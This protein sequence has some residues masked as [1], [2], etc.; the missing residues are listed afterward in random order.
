NG[1]YNKYIFRFSTDYEKYDLRIISDLSYLGLN[2]VVLD[3]GVCAHINDNEDL[4]LFSNK[5]GATDVKVVSDSLISSDMQLYKEGIKV[6][7]PKQNTLYS[8][9]TRNK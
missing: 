7:F 5:M 2:F 9:S 6:V 1:K 3:N 8:I 4:E